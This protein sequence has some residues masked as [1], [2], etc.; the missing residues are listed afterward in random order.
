M[1]FGKILSA[2]VV[3]GLLAAAP[4]AAATAADQADNKE[5]AQP[6]QERQWQASK[7]SRHGKSGEQRSVGQLTF[8]GE[9]RIPNDEKFKDTLV[10][11]LSGID[12]DPKTDRWVMISDDRSDNN[13]ARFYT[14]EL[15]YDTKDFYSVHITGVTEFKQPDG[16]AYPNKKQYTETKTGVVSD[17]ESI[18]FD[19]KTRSIWYTSE[20]DR[21]LAFDPFVRQANK[22]GDYVSSFPIP[23]AFKM[24]E[25]SD[26]SMKKGFRNNITLEGSSFSPDGKYYFTAMEASLYQDGDISTADSGSYARMTKY[27]R[28]GAILAEYAYRV[29]AIPAKPGEGKNADNGV[30]E[31]L[32]INDHQFL[33]LERAG[34]QASD[35]QYA[36]YIRIYEV[37]TDQATNVKDFDSLKSSEFTPVSKKLVLDLNTLHLPKLDNVEG[38]SWGPKLKNGH[39]SLVLISDNN[40]NSSQVTQ[41]LAFDVSPAA[42]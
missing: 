27:D 20:G 16:T 33:M 7:S 18:R 12:Y 39:D 5:K 8:I 28:S 11:G 40:F 31:M 29:D 2:S 32:A 21:S 42:K 3:A 4:F 24:S 22:K 37:D 9:Q 36:N 14:G 1:K 35:G 15:N 25:S 10:G 41:F 23:E 6:H 26:G 34:V 38:I 13:P 30:S 17:L 19:P